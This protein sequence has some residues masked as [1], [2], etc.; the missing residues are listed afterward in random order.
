MSQFQTSQNRGMS[1]K[2]ILKRS[3]PILSIN[4]SLLQRGFTR[5]ASSVNASLIITEA[6]N[7]AVDL[8]EDLHLVTL[9]ATKAF[10]VMWQDSLMRKIYNARV[11]G[12]LWLTT[13]NLYRDA[14]TSVKW[15]SHVSEPFNVQQGVRQGEYCPH[16]IINYI[17]TI[18]SI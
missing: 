5:N 2:V 7:E 8:R 11:D 9:D 13:A 14:E 16:N 12:S 1:C 3:D 6:Q 17:T 10:D 15:S 18:Y 4:Q